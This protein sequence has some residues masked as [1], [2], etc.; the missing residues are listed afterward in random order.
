VQISVENRVIVQLSQQP[1]DPYPNTTAESM[2]EKPCTM[3]QSQPD[4]ANPN[5]AESKVENVHRTNSLLVKNPIRF[6]RIAR[7]SIQFMVDRLQCFDGV[8]G[9]NG[10]SSERLERNAIG[11]TL[12]SAPKVE[13]SSEKISVQGRTPWYSATHMAGD[14]V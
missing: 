4:D 5:T 13:S 8:Y 14:R 11:H 10:K 9:G 2:V 7:K 12:G 3:Q 1:D 6:G